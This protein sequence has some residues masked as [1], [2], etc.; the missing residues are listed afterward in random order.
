[1]AALHRL[2]EDDPRA[3]HARRAVS[4]HARARA[5]SRRVS[6]AAREEDRLSAGRKAAQLPKADRH[7]D[8]F[9]IR[10]SPAVGALERAGGARC[11]GELPKDHRSVAARTTV[12]APALTE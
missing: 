4:Q 1:M 11:R 12:A 6:G 9:Y 8:R 3:A 5:R 7:A 10:Q 2:Y